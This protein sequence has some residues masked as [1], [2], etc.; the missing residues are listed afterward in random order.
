MTSD[1]EWNDDSQLLRSKKVISYNF[2]TFEITSTPV[3]RFTT[4]EIFLEVAFLPLH[5]RKTPL[6]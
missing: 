3:I 4:P 5:L 1:L 2:F 6:I